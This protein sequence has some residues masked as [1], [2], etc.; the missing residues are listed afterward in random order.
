M[1]L[2]LLTPSHSSYM[3]AQ[4]RGI[5]SELQRV[6]GESME[7]LRSSLFRVTEQ[8]RDAQQQQQQQPRCAQGLAAYG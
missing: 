6:G 2:A 7:V 3:A 8:L 5:G 1:R 4:V